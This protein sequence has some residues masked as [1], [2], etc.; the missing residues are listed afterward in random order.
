VVDLSKIPAVD[1]VIG[2]AF[3]YFLL[4]VVI[5]SL[6]EAVS[7]V[8]QLRWRTLQRGLRELFENS[9]VDGVVA[10]KG[11]ELWGEFRTNPR[12]LA[13]WK[14]TGILRKR[15]PSYIPPRVFA[16]TLLDTLAPPRD[17]EPL[18]VGGAEPAEAAVSERVDALK[19]THDVVAQAKEAA[20][21]VA[22]PVL[23]KWLVDALTKAGNRREEILK[24]LE[25][26]FDSLT[27]R[28]SGWYKRHAT[29]WVFVF[30]VA[31]TG[32]LNVDSYTIGSRLW[33]DEAVRSAVAGEA[34]KLTD[35]TICSSK[36]S[37]G[38]KSKLEQATECVTKLKSLAL[39]IGWAEENQATGW[40]WAAKAGG[41]AVTVFALLLGAPFWFDT[42]SKLARLRN[43]GKPEGTAK[44]DA[45]KPKT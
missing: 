20:A 37:T 4:S 1:V 6:T 42:L 29:I 45:G 14:E 2:L 9:G 30:A 12:I 33:K 22:N 32:A 15:G 44:G 39:P 34:G 36:D 24:E 38:D 10:D 18:P 5:S 40:G 28:V 25:S 16:L 21:T 31:L 8:L 3:V 23:R 13:L 19:K 41:W 35:P 26:S 11:S 17:L 7:S 43:T 27:N